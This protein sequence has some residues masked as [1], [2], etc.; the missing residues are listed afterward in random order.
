MKINIKAIMITI[1]SIFLILF[2]LAT[3][4]IFQTLTIKDNLNYDK[5]EEIPYVNWYSVRSGVFGAVLKIKN[6]NPFKNIDSSKYITIIP[7]NDDKFKPT[8]GIYTLD[9]FGNGVKMEDMTKIRLHTYT[10]VYRTKF[11]QKNYLLFA[12]RHIQKNEP[13]GFLLVAYPIDLLDDKTLDQFIKIVT[14]SNM[15][16]PN[17][18]PIYKFEARNSC[19][20]YIKDSRYC[21]WYTSKQ[22]SIEKL[23][24]KWGETGITPLGVLRYPLVLNTDQQ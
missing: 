12:Q 1:L 21:G 24:K 9:Y 13:V 10:G 19:L 4:F 18:S 5:L 23:I 17:F 2:C 15:F 22:K 11:W 6:S 3:Y 16:A 7:P 14:T 20:D 8:S